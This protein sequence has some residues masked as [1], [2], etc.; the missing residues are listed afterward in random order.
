MNTIPRQ[1]PIA[2]SQYLKPDEEIL[3]HKQS[4]LFG[5]GGIW[6]LTN[7]RLLRIGE[8]G[9]VEET[10]LMPGE[11]VVY[12][13]TGNFQF[14][15]NIHLLTTQRILVLSV[16]AKDYLWESIPL[17]QITQVDISVIKKGLSNII[18]YGL[19]IHTE[20]RET[21]V[22]AHGGITTGEIDKR[23]MSPEERQRVNERFPRKV[24]KI[25]GLK[26]ALPRIMPSAMGVTVVE[27]YSKSD[28][29]WP[30]RCSSC[31]DDRSGVVYDEYM[32][33]SP[34]LAAGC[35]FGLGLLARI[36]YRIPYCPD[37]YQERFSFGK[38]NRAVKE[39]WARSNGARV[40]LCFENRLYAMEFIR[41]NSR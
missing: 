15:G 11:E 35:N 6:L 18:V 27:F 40:E 9:I 22:I 30:A 12:Y 33:E 32:I 2:F 25:T 17:N 7:R 13:E 23:K 36:T 16:G 38:I 21:V 19:R 8:K 1:S 41:A 3:L 37:C 14:S 10:L 29:E 4:G 39:G 26:F 31:Y 5:R 28:L 24:C 34:W 20:T